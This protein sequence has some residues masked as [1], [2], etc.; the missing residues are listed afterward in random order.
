[1]TEKL[2]VQLSAKL[3]NSD[4]ASDEHR[5]K[6]INKLLV[7]AKFFALFYILY[8]SIQVPIIIK[9]PPLGDG[10]FLDQI[11][12]LGHY[13]PHTELGGGFIEPSTIVIAAIIYI[14]LL[15]IA[16]HATYASNSILNNFIEITSRHNDV[17]FSIIYLVECLFIA[18]VTVMLVYNVTIMEAIMGV[19]AT[20]FFGA[21]MFGP[22]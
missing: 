7:F 9:S 1:M 11:R 4:V 22:K 18:V 6:N 12:L 10:A 15:Y 13:L 8:F 19:I 16:N 3:D 2:F 14:P 20:L 21:V 5:A 17:T